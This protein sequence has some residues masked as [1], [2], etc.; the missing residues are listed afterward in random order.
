MS[1]RA[2]KSLKL[3]K[4][5]SPG[6]PDENIA[7]AHANEDCGIAEWSRPQKSSSHGSP[8]ESDQASTSS[9][10]ALDAATLLAADPRPTV[11]FDLVDFGLNSEPVYLNTAFR[12]IDS[13]AAELMRDPGLLS[14]PV[15]SPDDVRPDFWSWIKHTEPLSSFRHR[16]F[17]WTTFVIQRRWKIICGSPSTLTELSGTKNVPSTPDTE[18]NLTLNPFDANSNRPDL[19]R[20]VSFEDTDMTGIPS[21]SISSSVSSSLATPDWTVD[22]PKGELS[23]HVQFT[24]TIDWGKTSL[25]PMQS[26]SKEFRQL[27]NKLMADP[28]PGMPI[29]VKT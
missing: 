9:F 19:S 5:D 24:R 28:H 12:M 17:T 3:M 8:S 18:R 14:F 6:S 1:S 26:W 16:G 13:L 25:G 11:V 23:L 22:V 7:T 2:R 20:T 27:A 10:S 21:P 4:Q 15:S 29:T